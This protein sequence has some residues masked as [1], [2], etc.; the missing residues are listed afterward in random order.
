MLAARAANP[1]DIG[2]APQPSL[3]GSS[4]I[5]D[6]AGYVVSDGRLDGV[7]FDEVLAGRWTVVV[8]D[9]S[10]LTAADRAYLAR[11]DAQVL[12]AR[13]E[14][15]TQRVL[16]NA[17][18]DVVVVR[19]DRIVLGSGRAGLDALARVVDEFALVP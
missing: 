19:P 1:S 4:L 10:V 17:Q 16:D 13:S 2:E 14:Q 8:A 3:S 5:V 18:T 6:G 11:V 15:V 12:V 9:E 7:V